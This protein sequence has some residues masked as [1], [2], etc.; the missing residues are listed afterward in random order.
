MS[1]EDPE[2]IIDTDWKAQVEKEKQDSVAKEPE[3]KDESAKN[4]PP[5]S[6]EMLLTTLYSQAMMSL[7]AMP[8]PATNETA[9]DLP[10]AK[11]FIDT[12]EMLQEKTKG[13]TTDDEDKMIE[14][15]LHVLRMAFVQASKEE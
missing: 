1:D 4:I 14:E 7:G 10:M 9:K 12:V 2:L 3:P 8:N 15:L 13:N 5:A 11:H 6:L